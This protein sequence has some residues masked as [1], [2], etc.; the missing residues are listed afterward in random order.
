MFG[1]NVRIRNDKEG[2]GLEVN[3]LENEIKGCASRWS[4]RL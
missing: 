1:G 2:R 4:Q 3:S